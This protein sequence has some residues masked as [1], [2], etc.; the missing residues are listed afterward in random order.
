MKLG[1]YPVD[2]CFFVLVTLGTDIRDFRNPSL[3][4]PGTDIR[5]SGNL[6]S[7]IF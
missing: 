5:D 1:T 3:V 4:T 7:I 6:R 2:N